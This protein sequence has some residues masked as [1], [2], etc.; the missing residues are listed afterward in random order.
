MDVI[1]IS[2]EVESPE[3][4]QKMHFNIWLPV[5]ADENTYNVNDTAIIGHSV[6]MVVFP[7]VVDAIGVEAYTNIGRKKTIKMHWRS[8]LQR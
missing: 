3:V 1:D 4:I 6:C 8:V 2:C 7:V 5:V